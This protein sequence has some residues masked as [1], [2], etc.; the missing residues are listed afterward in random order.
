MALDPQFIANG[1]IA[2]SVYALIALSFGLIYRVAKFF[3]FA[4]GAVYTSGTY[5]AFALHSLANVPLPVAFLS[6]IAGATAL[7]LGMELAVYR[8]LRKH[9]GSTLVLLLSSLGLYTVLQNAISL[10]FGDDTKTLRSW[11]VKEGLAL[12]GVHLTPVQ[13]AIFCTTA[14]LFAVTALILSRTRVG[15]AL[16]AVANDPDLAMMAGI[17]SDRVISWTFGIGS[18]LAG[19]AG[20]LVSLDIDMTPTM[21]MNALMMG[22][23][24]VII[25]GVGSIP[26]VAL[27]ALLLGMAQHLG[28]WKI[29]SQW[30]DA[31]AF[32]ILLIFLLFRPQG[33]LG[34]KIKKVTI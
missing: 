19:V 21:G 5:V 15:K 25:G 18:A 2:A 31:I 27:G 10:G 9:A 11:P 32:I 12:F 26:G 17:D 7:G 6:G 13:I 1:L 8:P 24:A 33:F 28:V 20:I 34:R 22:V 3:H 29:S 4:H 23:V 30:Q 14:V 16:C